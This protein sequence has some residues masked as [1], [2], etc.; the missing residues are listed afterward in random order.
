[1]LHPKT[2]QYTYVNT[3]FQTH[4]LQFG[5]DANETSWTSGGGPV[6]GWINT[7]MLDETGDIA[8]SQGWTALVLD[9]NGNGKRDAYVE[10][11]QAVDPTKDKRIAAGFYA[12]M[13]SPADGS[14]WGSVRVF[15]GA[16]VRV[17]PG[18]NP[19][20]TALAVHFQ[21]RPDPLAK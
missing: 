10:P 13:P 4:H 9:T 7:K 19:S 8:K 21:L 2:G 1:M 6:V 5:Y 18:A 14:V 11:N 17:V 15:P 16:V 12:V 3:C 20:E